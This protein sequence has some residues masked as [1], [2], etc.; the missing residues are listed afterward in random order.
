M[1][2]KH[3]A[4]LQVGSK[5][6]QVAQVKPL[7]TELAASGK[8]YLT[9]LCLTDRGPYA[10]NEWSQVQLRKLD[11]EIEEELDKLDIEL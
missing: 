4:I 2:V 3:I 8:V 10:S 11:I 5:T 1:E 9:D 6:C 7:R